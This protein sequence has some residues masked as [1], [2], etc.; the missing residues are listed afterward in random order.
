[1]KAA[2]LLKH[3]VSALLKA[4]NQTRHDL[5]FYCRRS[6]AWLSKIMGDDS[7]NVP[8]KYLDKMADFFGLATYQLLQ[9]GIS[10][11]TERRSGHDRRV[12]QER[13]ISG[14]QRA[15]LTPVRQIDITPQEEALLAELR[16][17]RYEDVVRLRNW[18]SSRNQ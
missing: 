13:R 2:A 4:R 15:A 12:G 10:P 9:P 5:A 7:R 1:M 3:N 17:L 14:K 6:D 8:I 11:L 16:E 18:I